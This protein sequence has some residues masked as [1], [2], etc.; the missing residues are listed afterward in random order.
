MA[1]IGEPWLFGSAPDQVPDYLASFG[2]KLIKD[3]E[4]GD[5]AYCPQRRAPINY[6]RIVVC[7][8]V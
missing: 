7:E 1:R 8:S 5:L 6:N 4:A 3:Y 2:F